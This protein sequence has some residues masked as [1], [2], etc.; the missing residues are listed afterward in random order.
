MNQVESNQI[1]LGPFPAL[2]I[3]RLESLL[4]EHLITYKVI[5]SPEELEHYRKTDSLVPPTSHPMFRGHWDY[6]LVEIA[7]KDL[8]I[9]ENQ[10]TNL[11]ITVPSSEHQ[12]IEETPEYFC[13]RCDD[14]SFSQRACPKHKT[15]LLLFSDW[16][17][18]KRSQKETHTGIF[19]IILAVAVV[20]YLLYIAST[21]NITLQ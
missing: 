4:D 17:A 5:V 21:S 1:L 10:L 8:P 3:K 19:R 12:Y 14:R 15:P 20:L 2:M 13:P 18:A 6:C 9:I 11:G 7:K 16:V